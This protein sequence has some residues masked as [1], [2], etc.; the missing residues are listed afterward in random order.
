MRLLRLSHR[1]SVLPHQVFRRGVLHQL[2]AQREVRPR[3]TA[4]KPSVLADQVRPASPAPVQPAGQETR[5]RPEVDWRCRSATQQGRIG[6]SGIPGLK[7]LCRPYGARLNFP[8]YPGLTP[9]ANSSSAPAG[10]VLQQIWDHRESTSR[11]LTQ[12][13]NLPPGRRDTATLE[14]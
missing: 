2:P 9:G 4:Y 12:T 7:N 6:F 10:L 13:L 5:S 1:R 14:L 3:G 11:V 8:L